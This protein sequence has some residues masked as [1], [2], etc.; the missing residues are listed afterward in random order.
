MAETKCEELKAEQIS[1]A[2]KGCRVKAINATIL[3]AAQ[4]V[5][6]LIEIGTIKKVKG[7]CMEQ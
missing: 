1:A 7:F 4:A 3:M 2:Q 6:D 5:N